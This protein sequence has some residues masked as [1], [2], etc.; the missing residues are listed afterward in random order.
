MLSLAALA[1]RRVRTAWMTRPFLPMTLPISSLGTLAVI[2]KTLS[3]ISVSVISTLIMS[4]TI[5][6]RRK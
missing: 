1:E 6:S 4:E 2:L 5:F 3:S